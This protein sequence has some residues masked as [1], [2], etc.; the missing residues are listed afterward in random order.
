[1]KCSAAMI[2]GKWVEVYKDPVTS[3]MK[4]SKK[5]RQMLNIVDGKFVTRPLEYGSGSEYVD[6][7][8]SRY[9]DG[10][11]YNETNFVR[12]REQAKQPVR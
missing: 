7:L 5:G 11:V 10:H 6:H 4:K 2:K 1:M 12:V 8:I 3:K 9:K